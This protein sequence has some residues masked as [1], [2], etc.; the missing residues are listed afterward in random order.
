LYQCNKTQYQYIVFNNLFKSLIPAANATFS[1]LLLQLRDFIS[2]SLYNLQH[3]YFSKQAPVGFLNPPIDFSSLPNRAAYFAEVQRH[4]TALQVAWLT[5]V[6]I[7]SPHFGAA[8]ANY[9]TTQHLFNRIFTSRSNKRTNLNVSSHKIND[10]NESPLVIYELGGG[11]GTLAKD[12]LNWLR[13]YNPEVHATCQYTCIEISPA[14]AELQYQ[15]V[16]TEQEGIHE[17]QFQVVRGD[18]AE[19]AT[20][21][22]GRGLG[23]KDE[24]DE[25]CF[26]VA[27]EVLDNLPHDKVIFSEENSDGQG[28]SGQ[29][30]EALVAESEENNNYKSTIESYKEVYQPVGD[31]LVH[32]CL[33]TWLEMESEGVEEGKFSLAS[34]KGFFQKMMDAAVGAGAGGGGAFNSNNDSSSIFLPTGA[35]RLFDTLHTVRPNHRL[36]A[37]DFDFLPETI[38]SGKNA[39]LVA[40]TIDGV[41]NDYGTYLV[42]PGVADIFFPSDFELLSRLYTLSRSRNS[43]RGEFEGSGARHMKSKEFFEKWAR[44]TDRKEMKERILGTQCRDGYDPLLE[45]YSNTAILVS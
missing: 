23:K 6:E 5:P 44:T 21:Q 33:Q 10:N 40:T 28:S 16:V 7:F 4:Y 41:T 19:Y 42:Q 17:K 35:L 34:N 1:P 27:M 18:A 29:W 9:L 3:G 24:K 2:D 26:V 43:D 13:H 14:L 45:D 11:T 30:L 22:I 8:I 12:I 25:Q 36:L 31:P 37:A 38:I 15:R 39:P 32:Q 20:W